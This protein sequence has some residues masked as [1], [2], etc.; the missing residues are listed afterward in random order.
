MY[1]VHN[2]RTRADDVRDFGHAD[3]C[4][5]FLFDDGGID[6]RRSIHIYDDV[7]FMQAQ[8][9]TMAGAS[10]QS[11]FDRRCDRVSLANKYCKQ[12]RK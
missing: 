1:L 7:V 12:S 3:L 9:T 4:A 2:K 5:S 10:G 11:Q 6:T 8:P